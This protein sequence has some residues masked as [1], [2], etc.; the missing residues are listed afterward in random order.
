[1]KKTIL[2]IL[3]ILLCSFSMV[4]CQTY[5]ATLIHNLTD[6]TP[7]YFTYTDFTDEEKQIL[8][9]YVGVVVPFLPTDEYSF[10]SFFDD[11]NYEYGIR[12]T[13]LY[14]TAEDYQAYLDSLTD[15]R[16]RRSETDEYGDTWFYFTRGE[17]VLAT[18]YYKS[19]FFNV[20][21]IFVYIDETEQNVE[22]GTLKNNG[23]GLPKGTGG[24]YNIDFTASDNATNVSDLANYLDSCPSTGTPA[25]LVIPVQFRDVTAASK[26]YSISTIKTAF[27][28][29][30]G[31]TDYYSVEEYYYLSSYGQLDLDITV[32][33]QW[34]TP[35]YNSSY[36]TDKYM[37]ELGDEQTI[38]DMMI[39]NEALDYLEEKMDLS[40]F[41]S[42]GNGYI[43]A[44]IMINTLDVSNKNTF[45]WAY[46]FWNMYE[47]DEGTLYSYDGVMANDYAWMSYGFMHEGADIFGR[48][49]Y[50]NRGVITTKTYIH[51]FAHII[52]AEDYYDVSYEDPT[53]PLHG[54][55]IM[56]SSIGDHNPLTKLN[57]GW[58]DSSRLVTTDKSV[59]LSLESFQKS[60]DTIIIANDFDPA[61][62]IY[63]EYFILAY[64][65]PEGLNDSSLPYFDSSG[66]VI[67]HV[68]ASLYYEKSE[69][70][71]FY[72]LNHDNAAADGKSN[73]LIELIGINLG[74]VKI[75]HHI[76][77]EGMVIAGLVDDSGNMLPY[78]ITVDTVGA[79]G[80]TLTFKR[81]G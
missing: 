54:K 45:T 5:I 60:G 78:I 62:G 79:D 22:R 1:M 46:R 10:S 68:N 71:I 39:M 40:K 42:D 72:F 53:G 15:F 38:G 31:S 2:L 52:G 16:Y 65:S 55:D 6:E 59:T 9:D 75:P 26:G 43:D 23:K 56:D 76:F 25:V 11:G 74:V 36:Y 17:V 24:V 32:L 14:N 27:M 77:T 48:P 20:A 80:A 63:Q 28:G 34:F 41:D 81:I 18:A 19:S 61:L 50:N 44:V 66:I 12:F 51:E 70:G 58:I 33:D 29:K 13:T 21:D 7:D 64:Y 73:L 8:T 3:V 35:K 47:N 67:Y 4:S 30:S 57:Y 37:D 49:T 69:D